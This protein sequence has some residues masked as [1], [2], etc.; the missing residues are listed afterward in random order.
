MILSLQFGPFKY[1]DGL[2]IRVDVDDDVDVGHHVD[3]DGG[4]HHDFVD[5]DC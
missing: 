1:D 3:H 2:A 5:D 4:N